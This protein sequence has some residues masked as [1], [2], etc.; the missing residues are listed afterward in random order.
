MHHVQFEVTVKI[1]WEKKSMT[2]VAVIFLTKFGGC[3]Y[4]T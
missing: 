2:E 4:E 3:G 1:T